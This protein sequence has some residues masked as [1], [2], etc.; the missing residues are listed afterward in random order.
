MLCVEI[1][2]VN[3]LTGSTVHNPVHARPD[4]GGG[5]HRTGLQYDIKAAAVEPDAAFLTAQPPQ[6][7]DFRMSGGIA[8]HLGLVITGR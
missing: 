6:R 7:H 8:I 1:H 2:R 4:A 3:I 5:A